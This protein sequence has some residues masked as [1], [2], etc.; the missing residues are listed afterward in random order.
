M[1]TF[2]HLSFFQFQTMKSTLFIRQVIKSYLNINI[3]MVHCAMLRCVSEPHISRRFGK[4]TAISSKFSTGLI[5]QMG[6]LRASLIFDKVC[7]L[8]TA[9]LKKSVPQKGLLVPKIGP[10]MGILSIQFLTKSRL[11]VP[12]KVLAQNLEKKKIA[13]T[14]CT[15]VNSS[16]FA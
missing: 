7:V 14:S 1:E 5:L 10:L 2:L 13:Q 8:S 15:W 6:F 11:N 3:V 4:L 12:L 16:A 9:Q